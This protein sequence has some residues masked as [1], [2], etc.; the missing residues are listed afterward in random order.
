ME[1]QIV[2]TIVY[3]SGQYKVLASR[4]GLVAYGKFLKS[5]VLSRFAVLDPEG[6]PLVWFNGRDLKDDLE[7]RTRAVAYADQL[8]AKEGLI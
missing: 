4:I 8:A 3:E 1:S 5:S 6:E 7:A 2:E